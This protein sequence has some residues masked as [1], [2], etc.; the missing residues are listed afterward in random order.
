MDDFG[1]TTVFGNIHVSSL[2]N[3]RQIPNPTENTSIFPTRWPGANSEN[4]RRRCCWRQNRPRFGLL[5]PGPS[6]E[7]VIEGWFRWNL[8]VKLPPFFG[9]DM[10]IFRRG[11][12]FLSILNVLVLV[13]LCP[14]SL[15]IL[16]E[17]ESFPRQMPKTTGWCFDFFSHVWFQKTWLNHLLSMEHLWDRA[18]NS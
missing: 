3:F 5:G 16:L 17:V 10:F 13:K 11:S 12:C 14:T 18:T 15:L 9:G 7:V 1:G 2:V 8:L 6:P 4:S